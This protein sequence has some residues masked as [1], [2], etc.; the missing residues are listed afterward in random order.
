M[1][2]GLKL[3][4]LGG[5]GFFFLLHLQMDVGINGMQIMMMGSFLIYLFFGV[6]FLLYGKDED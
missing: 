3:V 6:A 2:M 4:A 1:K 5:I